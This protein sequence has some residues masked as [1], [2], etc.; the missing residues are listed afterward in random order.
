MSR[1]IWVES[2]SRSGISASSPLMSMTFLAKGFTGS[3]GW[4]F[5]NGAGPSSLLMSNRRTRRGSRRGKGPRR[6]LYPESSPSSVS[7]FRFFLRVILARGLKSLSL[8][9][10]PPSETSPLRECDLGHPPPGPV[11]SLHVRKWFRRPHAN[12]TTEIH[13][14]HL[15]L[16]RRWRGGRLARRQVG[17]HRRERP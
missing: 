3:G 7:R 9:L 10:S 12:P 14:W 1:W 4:S 2:Q 8:F 15:R 6:G 13:L 5:L 11:G 17:R 16:V